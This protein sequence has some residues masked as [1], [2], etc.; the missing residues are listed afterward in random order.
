LFSADRLRE[1]KIHFLFQLDDVFDIQGRGCVLVPGIPNESVHE[2]GAGTPIF[3][4]RPD[5]SRL[6]TVILGIEM[7]ERGKPTGHAPF[8][9]PRHIGKEE[10]PV[11]SRIYLDCRRTNETRKNA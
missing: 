7:I 3:I 5:G 8:S 9:V 11:G 4:E 1:E 10:L 2:V 6:E